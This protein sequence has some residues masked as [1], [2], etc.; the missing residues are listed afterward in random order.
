MLDNNASFESIAAKF[1]DAPSSLQNGNLGWVFADQINKET[2]EILN[3]TKID[4]VSKIIKIDNG[5]KIIK[6][7]NKRKYGKNYAK[8]WI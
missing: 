7:H 5:F 6:V 8:S 1:S 2:K 3:K 4:Q